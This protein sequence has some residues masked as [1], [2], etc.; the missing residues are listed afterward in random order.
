MMENSTEISSLHPMGVSIHPMGASS[1]PRGVSLHPYLVYTPMKGV[2]YTPGWFVY[3][4]FLTVHL[5]S[6]VFL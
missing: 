6:H 5:T 3:T 4:S 1:H 2:V